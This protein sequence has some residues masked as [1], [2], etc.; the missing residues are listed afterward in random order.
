MTTP[1]ETVVGVLAEALDIHRYNIGGS[2]NGCDWVATDE[3]AAGFRD[4]HTD[5]QASAVA[6]LPNIAIVPTALP[7]DCPKCS[8]AC[9][10]QFVPPS[11]WEGSCYGECSGY[12]VVD[13]GLAR[14]AGGQA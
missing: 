12:P 11:R 7:M 9:A 6:A 3:S 8:G 2:C 4:Q 14:A 5:H 10:W 1:N 13:F